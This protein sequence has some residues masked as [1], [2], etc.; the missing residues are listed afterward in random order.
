MPLAGVRWVIEAIE[1]QL[2]RKPSEGGLP[3]DRFHVDGSIEGESLEVRYGVSV[4]GEGVGGYTIYNFSRGGY[5]LPEA[6]QEM[7]FAIDD[8]RESIR[9]LFHDIARRYASGQLG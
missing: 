4:T 7:S 3:R 1:Q 9:D 8:W 6:T 5:I 2:E